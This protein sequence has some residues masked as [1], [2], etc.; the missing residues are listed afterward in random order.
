MSAISWAWVAAGLLIPVVLVINF[1]MLTLKLT[2]TMNVDLWNFW[3]YSF[4]G[5]A[6][7]ATSGSVLWGMVAASVAA[8]IALLLAECKLADYQPLPSRPS[9]SCVCWR[10]A[11][12]GLATR[13]ATTAQ[14]GRGSSYGGSERCNGGGVPKRLPGGDSGNCLPGKP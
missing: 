8:I 13:L 4:I 9:I 1:V 6:V 5:A 14:S 11:C 12:T 7:T 10:T 2:K 3:Q